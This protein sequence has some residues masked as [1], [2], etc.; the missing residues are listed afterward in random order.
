MVLPAYFRGM[1]RKWIGMDVRILGEESAIFASCGLLSK[2][3]DDHK[4]QNHVIRMFKIW[5]I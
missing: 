2:V 5:K 3:S 4:Y 1:D